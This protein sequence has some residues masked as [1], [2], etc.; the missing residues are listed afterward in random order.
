MLLVQGD[1][2]ISQVVLTLLLL[3]AHLLLLLLVRARCVG[4]ITTRGAVH[5]FQHESINCWVVEASI[6][7][8]GDVYM[9][10]SGYDYLL[11]GGDE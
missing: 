2:D 8:A 9:V 3:L 6:L 7:I 10:A 11:T 4:P 1:L 5:L